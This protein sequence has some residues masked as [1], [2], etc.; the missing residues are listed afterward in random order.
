M[1]NITKFSFVKGLHSFSCML[2]LLLALSSAAVLPLSIVGRTV[3]S[4]YSGGV[5]SLVT[6]G[7][8]N[9][10]QLLPLILD[11]GSYSAVVYNASCACG[12]FS[13]SRYF[14]SSSATA[15]VSNISSGMS[16]KAGEIFGVWAEDSLWMSAP[17][18]PSLQLQSVNF[19]LVTVSRWLPAQDMNRWGGSGIL[20]MGPV[21]GV[22]KAGPVPHV[23]AN[24]L[25][26]GVSMYSIWLPR[27]LNFEKP[28][29]IQLGGYDALPIDGT[30]TW[31]PRV[32]SASGGNQYWSV[33][34]DDVLVDGVS[35]NI[36]SAA[37]VTCVGLLDTGASIISLIGAVPQTYDP[38]VPCEKLSSLPSF[39]IVIEGTSFTLDPQDYLVDLDGECHSALFTGMKIPPNPSFKMSVASQKIVLLDFGVGWSK[40][41]STIFDWKADRMGFIQ[42]E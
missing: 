19:S 38:I 27:G 10:P 25:A 33:V 36:C 31:A 2:L 26:E 11:S 17:G 6:V 15:Q 28:G 29:M 7:V 37:N 12:N 13:S 20:G 22:P 40:R 8:G 23:G 32:Q 34:V 21:T 35:T 1:Q 39:S 41:V 4:G 3:L 9:P 24:L 42:H 5:I 30:P 18:A 16:Y 14:P